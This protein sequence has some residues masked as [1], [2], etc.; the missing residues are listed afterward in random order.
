MFQLPEGI[1]PGQAILAVVGVRSIL[2]KSFKGISAAQWDQIGT[3]NKKIHRLARDLVRDKLEPAPTEGIDYEHYLDALSTNLDPDVV[4]RIVASFPPEEHDACVA[5]LGQLGKTLRYLR[6]KLPIST[7][8]NLFGVQNLPPSETQ[9]FAFEDLLELAD[10]PLLVFDRVDAGNLTSDQALSLMQLYPDI[11][12]KVV[13]EIVVR[14]AI[15][16]AAEG[17]DF[18]P[19][20][21]A[22]LAVLLAVPG[23]DP[24]LRQQLQ[25]PK[26]QQQQQQQAPEPNSNTEAK[27]LAPASDKSDFND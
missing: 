7:Y 23:V 1:D 10:Q 14:C 18:D 24:T 16:K 4:Q 25:A 3:L 9:I 17:D 22:P 26:P 11:Y 27:K 12:A 21:E 19:H 5:F 15:E 13:G 20:F 8:K 2:D 6:G